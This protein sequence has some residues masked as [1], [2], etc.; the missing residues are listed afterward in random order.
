MPLTPDNYENFYLGTG[1]ELQ[2]MSELF[3]LGVEAH[4]L[5]PDIG[6]DLLV[7][8]KA[9][10]RY[11]DAAPCEYHVQVKSTFLVNQAASFYIA[12]DELAA[13][14]ADARTVL[15]LCYASPLIQAEPQSFERGDNEPWWE[16]EMASL[17]QHVYATDFVNAK[18][19]GCL[20]TL[21]FKRLH[22]SYLWLNQ[23]QLQRALQ[24]GYF[25]DAAWADTPLCQ[26]KLSLDEYGPT[27]HG[28]EDD[29]RPVAEIRNL[30]YLLKPSRGQHRL[31]GG[32]F[33]YEHY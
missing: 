9:A 8:N 6:T 22:L 3:L 5:N 18:R 12:A 30:Y 26:L 17:D 25:Q 14:A 4:K 15:V 29:G 33:L 10:Q 27:L 1:A 28:A 2:V 16:A 11:R 32:D 31:E 7:T 19:S 13:L 20:S 21:D 23:R 24:E